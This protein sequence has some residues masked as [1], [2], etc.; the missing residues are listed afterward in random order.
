M[1]IVV[2]LGG[3]A[4]GDTPK[5]QLELVKF[6]AV[7]ITDLIAEGHHVTVVHGN[8][9]QVGMIQ[10]AFETAHDLNHKNAFDAFA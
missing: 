1:N 9:P 7:S 2:A 10:S 6:A 5:E 4:L 3:N 8:G